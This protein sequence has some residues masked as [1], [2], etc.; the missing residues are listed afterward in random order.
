M[1]CLSLTAPR[2][3]ALRILVHIIYLGEQETPAGKWGYDMGKGEQP[4]TIFIKQPPRGQ[5]SLIL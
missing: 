1:L 3:Q 4:I 2:K 5:L